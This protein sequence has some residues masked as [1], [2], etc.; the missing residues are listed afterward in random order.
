MALKVS[1]SKVEE[2]EDRQ[3][4][5]ESKMEL[6]KQQHLEAEQLLSKL[7][8]VIPEEEDQSSTSKEIS[9]SLIWC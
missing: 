7:E 9:V 4:L 1:K 8:S 2:S 5:L 6:L 3:F